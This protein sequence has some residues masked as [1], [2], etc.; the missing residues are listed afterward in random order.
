M[1]FWNRFLDHVEVKNM[2]RL[3]TAFTERNFD[4]F[5]RLLRGPGIADD[6]LVQR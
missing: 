2:S 6:T 5:Q 3:R 4:E 1:I